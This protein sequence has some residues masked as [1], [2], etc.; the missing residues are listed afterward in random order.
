MRETIS[1]DSES[2][3]PKF[4]KKLEDLGVIKAVYSLM[5]STASQDL[6][7]PLLDFQAL[8]KVLL[9]KWRDSPV[10][11]DNND[12]RRALKG[13]HAASNPEKPSTPVENGEDGKRKHNP[14]KWR[15]LG[16]ES[17]TPAWEFQDVGYLGMRDLTDYVRKDETGFQKLLLEQSIKPAEQRCPIARASLA[18]TAILLEHFEVEKAD[19]DDAKYQL[20]FESRNNYDKVFKPLILQ[21]SF[22]H[23]AGLGA[24]FRLWQST[25]AELEDFNKVYDLVRILLEAVVGAA[26]RTKDLQEVQT[27]IA[28]YQLQRLRQ[29]QMELLELTYEDTWGQ[30]LRQIKDELGHEALQFVK[31]QRIR[32]LLAGAWFPNSGG[33]K[34]DTG[35]VTKQD[36]NIGAPTSFRYARLS[37]NR[38]YL[39]FADFDMRREDQPGLDALSEKSKN[40]NPALPALVRILTSKRSRSSNGYLSN[41][42]CHRTLGTLLN[43][44]SQNSSAPF[45]YNQNHY[46]RTPPLFAAHH[47]SYPQS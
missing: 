12:H 37:H 19:P 20:S 36:L 4:I 5:Q 24:F 11:L 3:W 33:Y 2:D 10:N 45:A 1:N 17:E 21:W 44:N 18:V 22:L 40:T 32:C 8:S 7:Q 26:T 25:G 29:L 6:S 28:E 13:L 41:F 39:H 46:S 27:E 31:E 34:D 23:A 9:K 42:Q 35:P 47:V 16:F 38:R 15:R 43:F 14:R 30:H